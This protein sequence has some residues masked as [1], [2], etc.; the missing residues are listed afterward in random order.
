MPSGRSRFSAW[1]QRLS[2]ARRKA[3]SVLP[4]PVGARSSVLSPRRIA[5]HALTC[6]GEGASKALRNHLATAGEK[7]FRAGGVP[8]RA[9]PRPEPDLLLVFP[10]PGIAVFQTTDPGL[11]AG[12]ASVG[13]R[14]CGSGDVPFPVE[15]LT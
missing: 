11:P 12:V 9:V 15:T 3:A 1:R 8:V 5:G 7:A 6:A 4:D 14:A 2:M 13:G 10:F